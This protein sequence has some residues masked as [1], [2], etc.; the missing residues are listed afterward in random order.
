MPPLP[1]AIMPPMAA[2][3][4]TRNRNSRPK[5]RKLRINLRVK[6]ITFHRPTKKAAMGPRR[7]G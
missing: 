6:F 5:N 3:K 1:L 7:T 4:M 2:T